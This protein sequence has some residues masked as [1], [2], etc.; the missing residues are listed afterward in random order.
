MR[1]SLIDLSFGRFQPS[2]LSAN[3]FG[4]LPSHCPASNR[5]LG[6]ASLS[7]LFRRGLL[8]IFSPVVNRALRTFTTHWAMILTRTVSH[9]LSFLFSCIGLFANNKTLLRLDPSFLHGACS[10]HGCFAKEMLSVLQEG[11]SKL[12]CYL[13]Q[14]WLPFLQARKISAQ[15][16]K[17]Q[18]KKMITNTKNTTTPS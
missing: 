1:P 6:L 3:S 5:C 13:V 11:K 16:V 4:P 9:L 2:W 8:G 7:K 18:E 15:N 14:F 10:S 12:N 17:E